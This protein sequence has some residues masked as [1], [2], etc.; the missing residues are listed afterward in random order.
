[1]GFWSNLFKTKEQIAKDKQEAEAYQ[2]QQRKLA[3]LEKIDSDA[4]MLK[5]QNRYE[6]NA[7]KKQLP[8]ISARNKLV[9]TLIHFK[10]ERDRLNT[11]WNVAYAEFSWWNKLKYDE[12]LDLRELDKQI[13]AVDYALQRFD[14]VYAMK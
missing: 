8:I 11:A 10:H 14:N 5:T 7:K 2:S 1:M 3:L 4:V 6:L 9:S 12:Q 13:N